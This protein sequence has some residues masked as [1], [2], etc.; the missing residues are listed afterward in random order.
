MILMGGGSLD[1]CFETFHRVIVDSYNYAFPERTVRVCCSRSGRS[2]FSQEIKNMREH[3]IFV[4]SMYDRYRTHELYALKN[5]LRARYRKTIKNAK[6]KYHDKI[7][8]NSENKAG[9]AWNLIRDHLRRKDINT[10]VNIGADEFNE[11]FSSYAE[12][13]QVKMPQVNAK[14][15]H[16]GQR[17][18]SPAQFCFE[19]ISQCSVRDVVSNMRNSRSTDFYGL[20]I[21]IVKKNIDSLISPLT[22]LIN[23]C[24]S[25][26][27]YPKCLKIS[28]VIPIHKKGS[29]DDLNNFRPISLVPVISKVVE[30]VMADQITKYF[31]SNSLFSAAQFGF[32]KSKSTTDAI[33]D[34]VKFVVETFEKKEYCL[35]SF[36]DLT[37][38]FDC[39]P[40]D[41]LLDKL[42]SYGFNDNAVELVTSFLTDRFQMVF[43][44]GT[45][46]IMRPIKIGVPQG[47]TLG[48]TLF[49]IFINDFAECVPEAKTILFVDDTTLALKS[50]DPYSL[51]ELSRVLRSRALN[52]FSVNGL[53]VNEDKTQELMFSL[54]KHDV[55]TGEA[56][57]VRFLGVHLDSTLTWGTHIDSLAAKLSSNIF[58]LRILAFSLSSEVLRS[59]YFAMIESHLKYGVLLWGGSSH[60]GTVFR[61]QRRA[62]RILGGLGYRDCC[63][64]TFKDLNL[65]TFPSIFILENLLYAHKNKINFQAQSDIHDY[66]TRNKSLIRKDFLRLSRSQHCPEFCSVSLYNKLPG[67]VKIMSVRHFRIAV[68]HMLTKRV[69]YSINEFYSMT[70]DDSDFS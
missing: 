44:D 69:L 27:S 14:Y 59:V 53:C 65:L 61:L 52:W 42:K 60:A 31:E 33:V 67:G 39:V 12:K 1:D 62:V 28:K 26:G 35:T 57:S 66:N 37:K 9:A 34:L 40:H 25:S 48:P 17:R 63:R 54:R 6:L 43:V 29:R 11:H 41:R 70:L 18:T 10:R 15:E 38:A 22:K 46:S 3:L 45:Y 55:V 8:E 16:S 24:L 19:A 7:I 30:K 21:M 20:S 47:S 50:S 56:D 2:W 5:K 32:R 36:I 49:I 68:K 51:L 13:L 4:Q 58:A 23:R 64:N